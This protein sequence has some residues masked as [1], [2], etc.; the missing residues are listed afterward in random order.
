MFVQ[1]ESA[2]ISAFYF[3][4]QQFYAN[5]LIIQNGITRYVEPL[6]NLVFYSL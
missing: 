6:L 2:D 3:K 4:Y 1:I 5:N